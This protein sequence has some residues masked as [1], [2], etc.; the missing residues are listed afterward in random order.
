MR[1]TELTVGVGAV[2]NHPHESYS[3]LRPSVSVR[4]ELG[5]GDD[6]LEAAAALRALADDRLAEHKAAL[7]ARIE[8]EYEAETR[9]YR[10]ERERRLAAQSASRATGDE[11]LVDVGF[12]DDEEDEDDDEP[13]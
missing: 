9:R 1:I 2:F 12:D 3:K 13:F 7:L 11:D 8:A 10:E 5:P 4:A 6:V